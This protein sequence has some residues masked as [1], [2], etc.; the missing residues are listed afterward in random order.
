MLN[1]KF[2]DMSV[3][4]LSDYLKHYK[5]ESFDLDF[6]KYGRD[7][8]ETLKKNGRSSNARTYEI[9][10]NNLEQYA[11]KTLSIHAITSGFIINWIQW[12]KEQPARSNRKKGGRAESLYPNNIRALHNIAKREF[13]EEELGI[14]RIP[15]SPF[16]KV[17]LPDLPERRERALTIEQIR[18]IF[19]L[20]DISMQNAGNSRFNFARDMFMLSFMLIGMN[21][22]DLYNC[23][24]YENGRITYKRTKVM[25][26]RKDKGK[27]SIKVEPEAMKLIEKYRDTDG[28]RVFKFYKMYSSIET[29]TAAINGVCRSGAK[30]IVYPTGLKK[31]GETVGVNDL[32]FYAARH[33]WASIAQNDLDMPMVC[34]GILL[35][36]DKLKTNT[37]IMT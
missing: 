35:P 26:R 6:I 30:G 23:T 3:E 31:I 28:E 13:N 8:V 27:I 37:Y 19:A 14:I 10:L 24:E 21:E 34:I 15:L 36:G 17:K 18:D 32:K 4:Q 2:D 25:N 1:D 5:P 22:A 33:S 11:G 29:F 7:Y 9:A 16:Q 12:I 20:E